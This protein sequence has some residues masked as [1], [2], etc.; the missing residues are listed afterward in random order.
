MIV[1]LLY[2]EHRQIRGGFSFSWIHAC[3]E[4]GDFVLE[5]VRTILDPKTY[6]ILLFLTPKKIKI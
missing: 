1:K 4:F 6:Q 2:I 3:L 5:K